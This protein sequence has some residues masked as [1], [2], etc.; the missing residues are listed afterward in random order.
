MFPFGLFYETALTNNQTKMLL[1][2]IHFQ[3]SLLFQLI[4]LLTFLWFVL[5]YFLLPREGLW[6]LFMTTYIWI[7]FHL[8][9]KICFISSH[10]VLI[11]FK[12]L[13]SWTVRNIR[14]KIN[15]FNLEI[16]VQIGWCYYK[17]YYL[18]NLIFAFWY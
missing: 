18:Y 8:W 16:Y 1:Q 3:F 5:F 9:R 15:F 13:S 11:S 14:M 17:F 6:S 10:S 2:I 4:H 7:T 12:Y